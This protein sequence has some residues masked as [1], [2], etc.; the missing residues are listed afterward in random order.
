MRRRPRQIS[1]KECYDILKL[2]KDADTAD[3]KRAYRRRAFELHPDLNPG[4]KQAESRFKDI[5]AAYDLLSDPGKRARFDRGEIDADGRETFAHAHAGAGAGAGGFAGGP[6]GFH[7]NFGGGAPEDLFENLFSGG[8]GGGGFGGRTR[9]RGRCWRGCD[10]D[11][12]DLRIAGMRDT[13][14]PSSAP[15]EITGRRSVE[16]RTVDACSRHGAGSPDGN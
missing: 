16:R 11:L 14:A 15:G 10:R 13:A 1:L 2:K 6:G 7:F 8:L 5:N 9:P 4:D 12:W 3:L